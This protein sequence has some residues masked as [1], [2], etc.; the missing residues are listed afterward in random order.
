MKIKKH[1]K[2]ACH[3]WGLLVAKTATSRS[4]LQRNYP[5]A[6]RQPAIGR[7]PWRM[8]W[9]VRREKWLWTSFEK[10]SKWK[11]MKRNLRK[12]WLKKSEAIR[13]FGIL[14]VCHTSS[15]RKSSLH[16]PWLKTN[17]EKKVNCTHRYVFDLAEC[18]QGWTEGP[19]YI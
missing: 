2:L 13:V 14:K 8:R 10:Q 19:C 5:V 17:W 18:L 12:L 4:T 6:W 11:K 9:R 16:G 15:N 7:A 3:V 1:G